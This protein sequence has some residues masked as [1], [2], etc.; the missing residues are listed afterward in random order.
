[1]DVVQETLQLMVECGGPQGLAV[2]KR[3]C[4]TYDYCHPMD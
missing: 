2:V 4:L 3:Y 1:M